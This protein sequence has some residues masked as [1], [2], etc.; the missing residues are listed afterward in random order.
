MG[1]QRILHNTGDTLKFVSVRVIP[2]G[3]RGGVLSSVIG[4]VGSDVL[5][6]FGA[7]LCGDS[8]GRD[9]SGW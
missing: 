2:V 6:C 4:A 5:K 3:G 8:S 1:H 7:Y 9:G